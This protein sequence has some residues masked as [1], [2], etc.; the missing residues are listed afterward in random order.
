[1]EFNPSFADRWLHWLKQGQYKPDLAKEV[2][3]CLI[4]AHQEGKI[5]LDQFR[6]SVIELNG[7]KNG[8][9]NL[10]STSVQ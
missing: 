7:I 1:M 6:T 2:A 3:D 10:P 8:L 4:Q 9:L 5:D